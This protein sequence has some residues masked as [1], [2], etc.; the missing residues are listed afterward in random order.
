MVPGTDSIRDLHK[1]K[2]ACFTIELK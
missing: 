2:I 1:L